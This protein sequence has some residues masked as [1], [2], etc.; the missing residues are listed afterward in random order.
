[1]QW[2]LRKRFSAGYQFD[3]NYSLSKSTDLA[4]Q[5]EQD[6]TDSSGYSSAWV[7]G[8]SWDRKLQRA[9]SDFDMRH[10]LNANWVIEVPFGGE[11]AFLRRLGRLA[12]VAFGGWQVSG[13]WRFT[14]GLPLSVGNGAAWPTNWCCSPYAEVVGPIPEQTNTKNGK[15]VGGGH[16]P[17]VFDDP[18][19]ALESFDNAYPGSIGVRNNLRGHGVFSIDLAVG[20]R[21]HLPFEG[22]SLQFRAEAFNLTNTVRFNATYGSAVVTQAATF[23]QYSRT[24]V[25][26]RVLQFGLRYEF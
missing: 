16:G 19:V 1:M 25:P 10:Q 2:T 18:Q 12:D 7:I 13:L 9:V 24:L 17:N 21:F 20:K 3:L 14:T 11:T 26:A 22:H 15:L 5:G 8:N 23:G 6:L 4:S